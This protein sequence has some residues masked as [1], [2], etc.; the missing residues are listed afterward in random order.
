MGFN[1]FETSDFNGTPVGLYRFQ[2]GNS[3]WCYH[4]GVGDPIVVDGQTF[5]PVAAS[6]SPLVLGARE[7]EF[8]LEVPANLP[9]V[10]LFRGTPPSEPVTLVVYRLHRDDPD[11]E[12]K[13]VW[14]GPITNVKDGGNSASKQIISR[15]RGLRRGGLRDTWSRGCTRVLF[16]LDG[17]GLNKVDFALERTITAITGNV[18]TLDELSPSA[19]WFDGGYLEWDA[20]GLG[21]LNRR[22]IEVEIAP[23]QYR[24]FGRADG[25]EVGM[26]L[27]AYPGCDHTTTMCDEKFDNLDDHGGLDFMPGKSPYDGQALM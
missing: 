22:T 3:I 24:L 26:T 16:G 17:C 2:W 10:E 7:P 9:V 27:N 5:T 21:T 19:T 20:D 13:I 8:T 12:P 23:G 11:A 15:N 1:T 6:E 18:V 25:L 14:V 4:G